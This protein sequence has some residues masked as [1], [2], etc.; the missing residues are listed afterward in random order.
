MSKKNK[1]TFL[2]SLLV[3]TLALVGCSSKA[4]VNDEARTPPKNFL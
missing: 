2:A 1:K 3:A 4:T